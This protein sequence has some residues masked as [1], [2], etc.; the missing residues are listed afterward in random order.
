MQRPCGLEPGSDPGLPA[1]RSPS[2]CAAAGITAIA[3]AVA[4]P[5]RDGGR[6]A[7]SA[8]PHGLHR[9]SRRRGTWSDAASRRRSAAASV[10]RAGRPDSRWTDASSGPVDKATEDDEVCS[11]RT[12]LRKAFARLMLRLTRWKHRRSGAQVVGILVGAPHTSNWDWVAMVMLTWRDGVAP[13]VLIKRELFRG[14]LAPLLRVDRRHPAGPQEPRGDGPRT[15]R[16]GE[17]R[18]LPA[19][20][21][22][23]GDPQEGGLLE[24][25]L[26]Q[27]RAADRPADL[28]RLHR[29]ADANHGRRSDVHAHRRCRGRHGPGPRLLRRQ[30]AASTRRCGPSLASARKGRH[31][32]SRALFDSA[33][34]V[35]A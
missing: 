7:S 18:G 23:G 11:R 35:R 19:R 20:R 28:A 24:V 32:T 30:A 33:R 10:R 26:L 14:P 34:C 27:D 2:R 1:A 6:R 31:G 29:R 25:R 13:K 9:R 17:G 16:A 8:R 3:G 15:P 21:R 4:A 5:H 12:D 22:R